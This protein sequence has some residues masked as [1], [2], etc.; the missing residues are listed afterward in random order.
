MH[1]SNTLLGR[2]ASDA[3]LARVLKHVTSDEGWPQCQLSGLG[4][5][6]ALEAKLRAATGRRYALAVASATL[7]L[8]TVA[9]ALD[10]QG[11]DVVTTPYTYGATL[12]GL[13]LLGARPVFADIDPATLTLDPDAARRALTP[14]TRAIFAV[15]I[16]G[17]P[18]DDAAL[19]ALADAHGLWYLADAAQSLGAWR[20]GRPASAYAHAAVVSF[21]VGKSVFAG[22]GGAILTDDRALYERCVWESQHP[23]RQGR[24]LGMA[25]VNEFG[26]GARIHPVAAIWASAAFEAALDRLTAHQARCLEVVA[27]LN[28]LGLT[29]PIPSSHDGIRPAFHRLTAAWAGPA[30]SLDLQRALRARGLAVTLGPSTVGVLYRKPAFRAQFR[31]R[32]RIPQR[33]HVAEHQARSR[34]CLYPASDDRPPS[35][36]NNWRPEFRPDA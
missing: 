6:A 8:L 14:R 21:T 3:I 28:E 32:Y 7:G 15:D 17:T 19:R 29:E 4:A 2:E 10:L 20:D 25:L 13:L 9:R 36:V 1:T 34:F 23:A 35:P 24:E 33:C 26:L 5:V 12:A 11:A 31:G 22:E 18:A 27:A 30:R 16:H